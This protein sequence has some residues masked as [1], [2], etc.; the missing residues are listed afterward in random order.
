M[1]RVRKWADTKID[2]A[3][4]DVEDAVA[5]SRRAGGGAIDTDVTADALVKQ[6]GRVTD[7]SPRTGQVFMAADSKLGMDFIQRMDNTDSNLIRQGGV[8]YEVEPIEGNLLAIRARE[9]PTADQGQ[10]GVAFGVALQEAHD[11]IF[12]DIWKSYDD[13]AVEAGPTLLYVP[14]INKAIRE[15]KFKGAVQPDFLT[16]EMARIFSATSGK[17]T[18]RPSQLTL[19]EIISIGRNLDDTISRTTNEQTLESL[20]RIRRGF[21]DTL[22]D[23]ASGRRLATRGFAPL[24][25]QLQEI[26]EY[27]RHATSRWR[28]GLAELVQG[29]DPSDSMPFV[30]SKKPEDVRRLANAIQERPELAPMAED[31]ILEQAFSHAS[32]P[33][34]NGRR[35]F[36]AERLTKFRHDFQEAL[37]QFP[38][39]NRMLDDVEAA[40]ARADALGLPNSMTGRRAAPGTLANFMDDPS[41]VIGDIMKKTP[42]ER[43]REVG[44]WMRVLQDPDAQQAFRYTL[45][46]NLM[47]HSAKSDASLKLDP[48]NYLD[49]NHVRETVEANRGMLEQVY[50]KDHV[51]R[52]EK[53][54]DLSSIVQKMASD[55]HVSSDESQL[56]QKAAGTWFYTAIAQIYSTTIKLARAGATGVRLFHALDNKRAQEIMSEWYANPKAAKLALTQITAES[57]PAMIRAMGT[58]SQLPWLKDLGTMSELEQREHR[59][60]QSR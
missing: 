6:G 47:A 54:A 26:N 4:Q 34:K 16:P 8:I 52:I 17:R 15:A 22:D 13:L 41:K 31:A 48:Y 14:K 32:V 37:A 29:R 7:V 58:A 5:S 42:A 2:D 45:W 24:A 40:Q 33:M 43:T 23:L 39:A 21:E 51:K 25:N 3:L 38:N 9:I 59:R 60:R 10:A 50:G 57:E 49:S 19:R 35:R 1:D 53:I 55:Q 56:I 12:Q 44:R 27:R 11:E 28:K 18:T 46:D 30:L 36:D 20:L